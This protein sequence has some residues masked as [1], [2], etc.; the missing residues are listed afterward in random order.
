M[1]LVD[2]EPGPTRLESALRHDRLIVMGGLLAVTVASWWWILSMSVDM[3]GPMTGTSAW[4]MTTTWDLPHLLL[5]V[6]MWVVMMTAMMLPGAVPM[7]ML[8]AAVV[9][10]SDAAALARRTYALAAG[11]LL[12]WSVFSVVAAGGQRVL[13]EWAIVSPM[14][15]LA[16]PRAGGVVLILVGIYQFTPLK[17]N[18]LDV[19]RSPLMLMTSYW[20]PGVRGAFVLGVRH[21]VFC[22]GCCWALML[23]LFVGGVMNAWVIAGVT[24]FVL[25]EK[26]MPAGRT[27]SYLGGGVLGAIGAW[28]LAHRLL[29]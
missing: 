21:G 24:L 13:S 26:V 14:M 19:C 5:L 9:R 11:Y 1:S 3:Y 6:A 7:V 25:L 16:D 4:A 18:C 2:R 12:M 27:T 20:R 29:G 15:S 22:L 8:Y 28:L 17:R 10:R 23:L